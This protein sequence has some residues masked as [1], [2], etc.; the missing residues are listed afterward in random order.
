MLKYLFEA[1]FKDG[2]VYKQNKEDISITDPKRS[3]FYDI[4]QKLDQVAQFTLIS[5]VNVIPQRYTVDL[6]TGL[7]HIRGKAIQVGEDIIG[8]KKLIFYRRHREHTTA[9][10]ELKSGKIL[11]SEPSGSELMYFIGFES[12]L[13]GKKVERTIGIE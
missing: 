10:Y 4:T 11:S 2:T 1:T 8:K 5:Q 3:C 13:K 9:T 7:F 6:I 12:R